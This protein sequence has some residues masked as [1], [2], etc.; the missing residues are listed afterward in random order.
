MTG[1]TGRSLKSGR[2]IIQTYSPDHFSLIASREQDYEAFY[3]SEI[4]FRQVMNYPPFT[5]IG[6]FLLNASDEKTLI[7]KSYM[8]K[9]VLDQHFSGKGY[10]LLGPAPANISK[11]KNIYK[12]RLIVKTVNYQQ[13]IILTRFIDK[14][15]NEDDTYKDISLQFDLNPMISY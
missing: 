1:R 9:Q 15:I 14:L 3:T 5:Q 12:W 8:L 6:I 11:I 2:S 13:L 4:S 10:E 7:N